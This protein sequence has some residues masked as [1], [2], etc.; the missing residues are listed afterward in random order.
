[1]KK[2]LIIICSVFL[3]VSISN[4]AEWLVC[5]IPATSQEVTE[6]AVIINGGPEVIVPYQENAAQDAVLLWDVTSLGSA[7]FSVFAIN[8]QNRRSAVATP[9]DLL[10]KPSGPAAIR[11][12]QQ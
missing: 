10:S 2:L 5:D 7:A 4:A 6:Y 3:M 11:L 9:F 12:I 8:S 1:M